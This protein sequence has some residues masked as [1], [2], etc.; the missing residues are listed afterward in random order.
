[1]HM[2]VPVKSDIKVTQHSFNDAHW[3]QST[4][5][6]TWLNMNRDAYTFHK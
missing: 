6:D 5:I 4:G 2:I 3:C 1:M